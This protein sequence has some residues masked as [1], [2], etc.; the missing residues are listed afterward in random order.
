M[1][2][3]VRQVIW[4]AYA[5]GFIQATLLANGYGNWIWHGILGAVVLIVLRGFR[6]TSGGVK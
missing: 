6:L 3:E 5:A 2:I 1:K 4:F